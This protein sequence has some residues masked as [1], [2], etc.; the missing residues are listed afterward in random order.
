MYL[1]VNIGEIRYLRVLGKPD[2]LDNCVNP[3]HYLK[4][5]NSRQA[6]SLGTCNCSAQL[7]KKKKRKF[8][9]VKNNTKID[10]WLIKVR[11]VEEKKSIKICIKPEAT[12][13]TDNMDYH[14]ISGLDHKY[15]HA[16]T[17]SKDFQNDKS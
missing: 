2:V 14:D 15:S 9:E 8:S 16:H 6:P 4:L 3:F 5:V 10:D 13:W 1:N 12:N 7:K 17:N 11:V